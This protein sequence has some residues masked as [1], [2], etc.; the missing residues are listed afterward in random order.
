MRQA[1]RPA[2]DA[3]IETRM[4]TDLRMKDG[5]RVPRGTRG[6]KLHVKRAFLEVPVVASRAG[7]VDRNR[8]MSSP[9]LTRTRRVPRGTRGS[10]LFEMLVHER[11]PGVASR[12][13][14]V[15]RN[16]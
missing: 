2:R 4:T 9:W 13:G 16:M 11:E 6:S 8:R 10:K 14:R 7:R 5:R 3:W 1:S 12:A 15:D